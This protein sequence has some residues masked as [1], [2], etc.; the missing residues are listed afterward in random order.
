MTYYSLLPLLLLKDYIVFI[1]LLTLFGIPL[2]ILG[3]Y[4]MYIHLVIFYKG[5]A[6]TA[7][8]IDFKIARVQVNS[9]D[10]AYPQT[11]LEFTPIVKFT[12]QQ[13]VDVIDE[14]DYA[15]KG[16]PVNGEI[17]NIVYRRQGDFYNILENTNYYRI[18]KWLV[19][20][21]IG[22]VLIIGALSIFLTYQEYIIEYW[23]M[24]NPPENNW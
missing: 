20:T 8:V 22:F 6:T 10:A 1:C 12:N 13:G 24:H 7:E 11:K 9:R 15:K 17:L 3:L 4:T 16:H 14:M 18:Y 19:P 23:Y 21:I 5:T 2:L